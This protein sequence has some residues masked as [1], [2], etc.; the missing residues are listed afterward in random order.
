MPLLFSKICK[1]LNSHF[2]EKGNKTDNRKPPK[3]D[4]KELYEEIFE[5]YDD[6]DGDDFDFD[7]GEYYDVGRDDV[8][9][10]PRIVLFGR[11]IAS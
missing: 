5:F 2:R 10:D 8:R 3:I 6:A 1:D 7:S 4:K 9:E 11:F